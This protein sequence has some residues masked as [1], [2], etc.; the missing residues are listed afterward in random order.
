MQRWEEWP[1]VEG[2]PP[3]L[4]LPL[5]LLP[6][7]LLPLEPR[8]K[9]MTT[10]TTTTMMMMMMMA[11]MAKTALFLCVGRHGLQCRWQG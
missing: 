10:T 5:L 6:L 3:L 7:M 8:E 2:N 4:R 9:K 1:R 11:L